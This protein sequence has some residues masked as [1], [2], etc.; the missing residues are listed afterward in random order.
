MDK[1]E[2]KKWDKEKQ[3]EYYKEWRKKNKERLKEYQKKWHEENKE[4]IKQY[5]EDNKEKI[6]EKS[7]EWRD[8]H[9]DER[10]KLWDEW[11]AKNKIRSPKRRFT[12]AKHAAK[13]RKIEWLLSFDEYSKLIEMPCYYCANQLGE[14]V[15]KSTGLDRLNSDGYYEL[16]NVVSCCYICNI[17]KNTF[18]SPEE[19]KIAIKA[20]LDFR[21]SQNIV[22][23]TT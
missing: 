15:K 16:T 11:Y 22:D 12:E 7:K 3:A 10:K 21:S 13:K 23:R 9:Q 8:S 20:V 6:A 1:K 2:T 5:L 14:P 19:T 17:I 18:L 4:H